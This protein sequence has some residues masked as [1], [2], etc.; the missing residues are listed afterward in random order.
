MT[1]PEILTRLRELNPKARDTLIHL[2]ADAFIEYCRLRAVCEQSSPLMR[3]KN[4]E[5]KPVGRPY[6]NPTFAL[7]DNARK[8]LLD[9]RL[10]TGDLWS[11]HE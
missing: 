3:D 11:D 4:A 10:K 1:K 8:A 5:G 9:M 6:P 2:W 7:R